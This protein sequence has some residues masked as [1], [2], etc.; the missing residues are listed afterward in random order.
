MSR[1]RFTNLIDSLPALVPFVGPEAQERGRGQPFRARLGANESLFGPSPKA[2]AAMRA[3]ADSNWM[4]ADPESHEVAY[5]GR[6]PHHFEERLYRP[7]TALAMG[8]AHHA[9]RLQSGRLGVYVAYLL[10]LV[11]VVLAAAKVGILG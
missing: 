1:P 4:Y 11:L 8:G 3:A 2:L 10:G 5:E 9:R 7:V 6:V